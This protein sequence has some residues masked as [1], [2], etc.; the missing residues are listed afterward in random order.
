[1][2]SNPWDVDFNAA[3]FDT[4]WTYAIK[5][6]DG[7]YKVRCMCDGSP[8]SCQAQILNETYV[9]DVDES[10][11]CKFYSIMAATNLLIYD[12]N[13]SNAFAETPPSKQGFYIIPDKAFHDWWVNH[14]KPP[15]IPHGFVIPILSAMQGH[16]ESPCL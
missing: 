2:F 3:V 5:A 8:C 13:V 10:D 14:E 16:L 9:N 11:A 12:A 7:G 15:P 4:I 1:M 6:L